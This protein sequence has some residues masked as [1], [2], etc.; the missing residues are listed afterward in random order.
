MQLHGSSCS[1]SL[2]FSGFHAFRLR[3]SLLLRI[4]CCDNSRV[5]KLF[6]LRCAEHAREHG[7]PHAISISLSEVV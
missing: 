3:N 5:T 4:R 1:N 6:D 2:T 7:K